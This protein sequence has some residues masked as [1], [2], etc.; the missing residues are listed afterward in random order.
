MTDL[1]SDPPTT[2]PILE[3][4]QL[5]RRRWSEPESQDEGDPVSNEDSQGQLPHRQRNANGRGPGTGHEKY[6]KE[7]KEWKEGQ[8]DKWTEGKTETALGRQEMFVLIC[9]FDQGFSMNP[10]W[11]GTLHMT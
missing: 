8:T 3:V 9:I 1:I 5:M 11:L 10:G 6:E 4:L 7:K 2:V